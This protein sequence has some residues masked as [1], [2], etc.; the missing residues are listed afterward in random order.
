MNANAGLKPG[1]TRASRQTMPAPFK[2]KN[3]RLSPFNY[4][5][6]RAYFLTLCFH[7]RRPYGTEPGVVKWL[8]GVLRESAA[9]HS[10]EVYAYCLMPDHFH[11]LVMGTSNSSNLLEFVDSFKQDTGFAF[12]RKRGKPLWQ[13]K[14]YDHILRKPNAVDSVAWYIWLNPVRKGFCKRP[15][16]YPHSGSFTE[17]GTRL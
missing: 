13:F 6:R 15:D 5:G 11:L 8:F 16:E 9:G 2:R 10:F 12:Q 1:A 4:W 17:A 7:N 3:I 14:F